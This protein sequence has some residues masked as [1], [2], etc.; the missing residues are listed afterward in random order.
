M[1][2]DLVELKKQQN[3]AVLMNIAEAQLLVDQLTKAIQVA[4][5]ENKTSNWA[6]FVMPTQFLDNSV[7]INFIVDAT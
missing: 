1:N 2:V 6:G 5:H 7:E 4:T 3:L